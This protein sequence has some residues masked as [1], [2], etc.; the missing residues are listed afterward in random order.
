MAAALPLVRLAP[1]EDDDETVVVSKQ[2]L[3]Q[4]LRE[5]EAENAYPRERVPK[6]EEAWKAVE[7]KPSIRR[8]LSNVRVDDLSRLDLRRGEPRPLAPLSWAE[9]FPV[10]ARPLHD[11]RPEAVRRLRPV[12][13]LR[14]DRRRIGWADAPTGLIASRCLFLALYGDRAPDGGDP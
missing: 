3:D 14:P 2:K 7:T 10:R 4:L 11:H 6:P 1:N 5:K 13:P 8:V 9:T 12:P